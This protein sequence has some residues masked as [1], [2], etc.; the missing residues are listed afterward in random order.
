VKAKQ[1]RSV[2]LADAIAERVKPCK[3]PTW[4]DRLSAEDQAGVHEIHARFKAGAYG[5]ASSASVAR[6]L[7]EEAAAAGWHIISERELAEWLRK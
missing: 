1:S 2:A 6:A 3:P 5:S 4:I 7:R